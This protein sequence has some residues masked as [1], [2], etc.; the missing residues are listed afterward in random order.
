MCRGDA[1]LDAPNQIFARIDVHAGMFI[2]QT[3]DTRSSWCK[4]Y[5][6][7]RPGFKGKKSSLLKYSCF[8]VL[9]ISAHF[10]PNI[11]SMLTREGSD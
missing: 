8:A 2:G 3:P 5:K 10:G 1:F 7:D 11:A 6:L 9:P 4:K